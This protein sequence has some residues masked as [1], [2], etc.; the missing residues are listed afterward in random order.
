[1]ALALGNV[2]GSNLFNTAAVIGVAGSLT[3]STE[4]PTEVIQRDFPFVALLTFSIFF[5]ALFTK[6]RQS[7]GRLQGLFLLMVS[8]TYYW[9]LF[10][11][12]LN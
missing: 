7:F 12:S 6:K 11:D 3:G 4:V 2:V 5:M 9:L 8:A 1:M 10:G